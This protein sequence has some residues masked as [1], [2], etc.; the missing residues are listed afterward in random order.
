[1]NLKKLL[2]KFVITFVL[3]LVVTAGMTYLYSLLV[4]DKGIVDWENAFRCAIL[5]GI[6]LPLIGAWEIEQKEKTA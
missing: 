6:A 3:F 1:M 2:V 5:V 4:H